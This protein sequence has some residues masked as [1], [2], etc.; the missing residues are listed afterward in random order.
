MVAGPLGWPFVELL[1]WNARL[2]YKPA[3]R[4]RVAALKRYEAHACLCSSFREPTTG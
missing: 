3:Y 2:R 1:T 4:A